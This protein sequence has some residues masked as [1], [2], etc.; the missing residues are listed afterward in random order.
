MRGTFLILIILGILV[1]LGVV[2]PAAIGNAIVGIA[3]A[4]ANVVLAIVQ[5]V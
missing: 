3:K 2:S 5:A 4:I 1:W